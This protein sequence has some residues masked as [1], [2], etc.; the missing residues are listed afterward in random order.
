MLPYFF[1]KEFDQ[2]QTELA[3][4]ERN[5]RH[6][7]Q[8]L[9][10]KK[11]ESMHL[12]DGCG[13]LITASIL[14]EHKKHC[15]VRII[16]VIKT[17]KRQPN[18]TIA[19]SPTKTAARFEWF[20]EKATELG[21]QKIVPLICQRTEKQKL[22]QER[23]QNILISAMLQSQ[24]IWLPKLSKAIIFDDFVK[25]ADTHSSTHK[26]IAHCVEGVKQKI[27]YQKND[28]VIL[29]GPEGDFTQQEIDEAGKN[30]FKSVSLGK[31]RLRTETAGVASAVI[32]CMDI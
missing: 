2:S 28:A 13:N 29:I 5:S 19:I 15:A 30:N 23:L 18:V 8:V 22:K 16:N 21:V 31:T 9:R 24:Q 17:D 10:M 25:A 7:I 12:T 4:D 27:H 32:L 11:G 26:F 14:D 20:L 1:T 3:L 6:I